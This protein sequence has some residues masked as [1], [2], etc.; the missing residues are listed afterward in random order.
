MYNKRF[1]NYTLRTALKN[2]KRKGHIL[3]H[4]NV[5][6]ATSSTKRSVSE[7]EAFEQMYQD[8]PPILVTPSKPP[9]TPKESFWNSCNNWLG[10]SWK[11][12]AHNYLCGRKEI[13]PYF[14]AIFTRGKVGQS[15]H[16]ALDNAANKGCV[17][18]RSQAKHQ[19]S[20]ARDRAAACLPE[21]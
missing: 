12:T 18:A 2:G 3:K 15:H 8:L 9:K 13:K 21:S 14:C 10:R 19:K 16:T 20:R 5:C 11:Q 4:T 17:R 6:A 7:K 1:E